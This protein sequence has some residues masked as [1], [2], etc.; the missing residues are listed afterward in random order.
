LSAEG[1]PAGPA[2]T[3]CGAVFGRSRLTGLAALLRLPQLLKDVEATA[4]DKLLMIRDGIEMIL[5]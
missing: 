4:K 5:G 3:S 2:R 1:F